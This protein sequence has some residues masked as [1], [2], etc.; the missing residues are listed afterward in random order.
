MAVGRLQACR[1]W[2]AVGIYSTV[3][4]VCVNPVIVVILRQF[5]QMG[6]TV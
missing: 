6:H 4:W 5:T 3:D 1:L 2:Q